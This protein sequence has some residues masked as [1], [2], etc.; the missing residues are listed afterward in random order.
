V[1]ACLPSLALVVHR[2]PVGE[3]LVAEGVAGERRPVA[4][5]TPETWIEIWP[6]GVWARAAA[7]PNRSTDAR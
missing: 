7:E 4:A 1:P 2:P 6:S 3:R 5:L